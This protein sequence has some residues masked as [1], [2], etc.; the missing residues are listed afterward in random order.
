MLHPDPAK[1]G[2]KV[3]NVR[4]HTQLMSGQTL[5]IHEKWVH[6]FSL[7]FQTNN[8]PLLGDTPYL[9]QEIIIHQN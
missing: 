4:S 5:D 7:T 6:N 1:L 3:T 8:G 9:V 2:Y